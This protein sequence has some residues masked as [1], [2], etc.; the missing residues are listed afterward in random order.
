[1][2]KL[3]LNKIY[4]GDCFKLIDEIDDESIDLIYLDPPFNTGKDYNILLCS[5]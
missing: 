1:M 3:E 4:Q 2:K 5:S